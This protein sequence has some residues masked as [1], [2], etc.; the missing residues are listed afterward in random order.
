MHVSNGFDVQTRE[1][2]LSATNAGGTNPEFWAE[3]HGTAIW[4]RFVDVYGATPA[5]L[6][7]VVDIVN[8]MYE[9]QE[10]FTLDQVTDVFT[11]AIDSGGSVKDPLDRITVQVEEPVEVPEPVPTDRN[12]RPLSASQIAWGEMARWSETASQSQRKERMRTDPAYRNF[13]EKNRAREFEGVGDSVV[14]MNPHLIPSED[15]SQATVKAIAAK[16]GLLV[17]QLLDWV[18]GYNA[19][20]SSQVRSLRSAASNPLGYEQYEKSFQAAIAAGLI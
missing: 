16:A 4:K 19:T 3:F 6:A 1:R 13:V 17:P 7:R 8:T 2:V 18:K 15:P 5:N 10:F 14:P 20:P 12:G 9:G 11:T